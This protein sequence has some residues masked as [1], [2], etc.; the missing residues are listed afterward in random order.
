MHETGASEEEA[1]RHIEYL[2]EETW[3]Q[4][5]EDLVSRSPFSEAF[6]EICM[7]IARASLSVYQHGDGFGVHSHRET[8]DKI[9]SLL[10]NPIPLGT[11]NQ[12]DCY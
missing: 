7:N 6:I 9:Q 10:V 2:I 1:R 8:K 4:M 12:D 11:Q 5:N 3:K